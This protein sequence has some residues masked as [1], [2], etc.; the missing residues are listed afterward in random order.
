MISV[1]PD[2]RR[3][4]I[5]TKE[6]LSDISEQ[7]NFTKLERHDLYRYAGGIIVLNNKCFKVEKSFATSNATHLIISRLEEY[8]LNDKSDFSIAEYVYKKSLK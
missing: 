7:E 2:N 5:K 6:G 4:F 8:F 1:R 3:F